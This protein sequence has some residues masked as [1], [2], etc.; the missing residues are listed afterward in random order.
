[1]RA[2]LC[3][4]CCLAAATLSACSVDDTVFS[5]DTGVATDRPSIELRERSVAVSEGASS[6]F[7]VRLTASPIVPRMVTIGSSDPSAVTATGSLLFT[8]TNWSTYQNVTVTA[9]DDS[10][11]LDES[12]ELTLASTGIASKSVTVGVSDDDIQ[13]IQVS[14]TELGVSEVGSATFDVTLRYVPLE[15][16][17][18]EITS[19][20]PAAATVSPT[21]LVFDVDNYQIAQSV[22]VTGVQDTDT[23]DGT[24]TVSLTE[25]SATSAEVVVTVFDAD[26]PPSGL[27][28]STNPAIYTKYQ[29]IANNT[30]SSRGGPVVSYSVQPDLP[31][32]LILDATTGVIHGTP[33]AP[34]STASYTVTAQN[35]HGSTSVELAISL[36]D[37]APAALE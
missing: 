8:A 21:T 31:S 17:T 27:D 20:D 24:T 10:N 29:P 25:P 3:F 30:P 4:S 13:L 32:G 6:T 5:N 1:M 33:I 37:P 34:A 14:A 11:L 28:Y 15:P 23:H 7:G 26:V 9:V 36:V 22:T 18:V 12:V 19:G 2:A 35:E 16:V